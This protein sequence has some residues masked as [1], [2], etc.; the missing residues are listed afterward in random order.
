LRRLALALAAAATLLPLPYAGARV[1]W[2]SPPVIDLHVDLSYRVNYGG[3]TLASGSGQMVASRALAAG[4]SGLVLPLFVP[5][6]VSPTGPRAE[7]LEASFT[8]ILSLIPATPP[9]EAPGCAPTLGVQ[10]WLAFEG[11]APLADD[12]TAI[13]RWMARGARIFGVVHTS[14]NVLATS[15][16][17][18]DP[19]AP[20]LTAKGRAFVHD[21]QRH[22]GL[23]D[24]SHASDAA[25]AD[26]LRIAGEDG[27]PVIAT[28]SNAR[29]LSPSA[30]NLTD[31]Q[32][33]AIGATGGVIGVNFH[34]SFLVPK[35][36]ARID[37][38]VRHIQHMI[39]VAG[40]D[41]VAIGSD[42]EGD[43][44]PP[45]GLESVSGFPRLSAA[46]L[47]GGVSRD[48]VT[49]VFGANALRLL[50]PPAP[51]LRPGS[52]APAGVSPQPGR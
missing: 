8:R 27:V 18:K 38:V 46:L 5:H 24:V 11:S 47:A 17:N 19:A 2:R 7:D 13:P 12:P 25:T 30:R 34:S 10:T 3:G 26:I 16:T 45:I 21:V 29:A 37:D 35:G 50:C 20:G 49:K 4:V 52:A 51:T 28:H 14:D 22:G 1:M 33:R 31:A 43:I 39:S 6:R 42:F 44:T 48:A 36:R 23:V 15:S 41:H 40:V 9:Y 32:L